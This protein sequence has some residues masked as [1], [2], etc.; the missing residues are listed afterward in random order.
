MHNL[1]YWKLKLITWIAS[2]DPVLINC[3]VMTKNIPEG[4]SFAIIPMLGYTN[5]VEHYE[6][7]AFLVPKR[8]LVDKNG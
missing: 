3:A 1:P 7:Q 5:S 4:M 6:D 2:G 8:N